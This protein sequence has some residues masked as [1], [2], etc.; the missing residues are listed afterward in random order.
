MPESKLEVIDRRELL[1][2]GGV[3]AAG[4]LLAACDSQGPAA[5]RK[6]LR[7]AEQKNEGVERRLFS[8]RSRDR[9]AR[10][11]L[12]A[13]K[14][15]PTYFVSPRMPMWDDAVRGAWTLE[16]SGAV[17][18]PLRL[19]LDELGKLP[20]RSQRVNHYCVEGWNAV[21]TW[22]GVRLS[23]LA[24]A[25]NLTS[26]A[27]YVDFQSFDSDYHE[28]WDIDSALHPQ[29]LVAYAMDGRFLNA[30]HGAPARI[31]SPIKLGYKNVK[32][33][34]RIVFLPARNGGYWSDQ[35]Y[36]WYAGT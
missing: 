9:V 1:R 14:E 17:K 27:H 30:N 16:V 5:A 13:G 34:T 35:G 24:R 7:L 28:S 36:E 19:T 21:A 22:A 4:L 25:V 29:T 31:H 11:A 3:A 12:D 18:R 10:G 6:L 2:L 26:D 15:F 8:E 32:Y 20:R 33:L 23:D